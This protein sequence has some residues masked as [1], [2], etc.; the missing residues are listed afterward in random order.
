[1]PEYD[2]KGTWVLFRAK[3][4]K[5]DKSPEYS[6]TLTL[7]DGTECWLDAWVK[8]SSKTGEKFFSGKYKPK[9]QQMA[10]DAQAAFEGSQDSD[11]PF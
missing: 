7:Q 9:E 8:T 2:D 3:N 6:G 10:D 11:A 5:T 4:R 1:M